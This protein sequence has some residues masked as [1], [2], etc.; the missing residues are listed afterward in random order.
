[1]VRAKTIW[2][3]LNSLK[4]NSNFEIAALFH[5]LYGEGKSVVISKLE[6]SLTEWSRSYFV[7]ALEPRQFKNNLT[8]FE[9]KLI[10]KLPPFPLTYTVRDKRRQFQNEL[11]LKHSKVILELS[12]L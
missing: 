3:Q 10:L 4:N 1:M 2:E 7:F 12:W 9:S 5:L 11:T 6:L 8:M